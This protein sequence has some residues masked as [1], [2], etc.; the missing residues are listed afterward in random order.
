MGI[1]QGLYEGKDIGD[2][3][4]TGLITYMR[5]DSTRVADEAIVAVREY[6]AT[7]Y[8]KDALPEQPNVYK[9]KKDAQDAHEAIR[10][11][12]FDLPPDAVAQYLDPDDLKLY[13]LI[14]ERFLASQMLPAVFDVTQVDVASGIYTLR[15]TGRVMKFPGFLALYQE[16]AEETRPSADDEGPAADLLPPLS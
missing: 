13:R 15:A 9:S 11:T 7:T 10:P 3:G 6:I 16:T 4:P 5:T 2:R 12:T 1:A 14:W 8:G